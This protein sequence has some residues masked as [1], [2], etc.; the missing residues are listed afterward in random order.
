[1][2]WKIAAKLPGKNGQSLGFA[3]PVTGITGNKL[4][5]AGGAN[6]PDSMPWLGGKKKYY[7]EVFV[8]EKKGDGKLSLLET[9]SLYL[10]QKLAYSG[11]ITIPD[12]I[13]CIGGETD[14]G[15]TSEVFLLQY[16]DAKK[17]IIT[18]ELPSLPAA[19]ANMAVANIGQT[20]YAAGGE[21]G[22]KA[23]KTFFKMD[24]SASSPQW[25]ELP[26]LP[27]AVSHAVA[28]AQS[29][30]KNECV[31]VIGGRTKS[32]SGL[33]ELH[34]TVFCYDP[35]TNTWKKVKDISD[36]KT[37]TSMS[38]ATAV[39][40]GEELIL[41]IGG[42]KG[43]IFH[44]IETININ[45][46]NRKTAEEKERLQ[47][48]KIQLLNNHPG[49]SRDVL[50]YNTTK[51]CWEKI[52]ELPGFGPVTTTAVKWNDEIFIPSGEIKPGVR[53]PEVLMGKVKKRNFH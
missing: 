20:I 3:G 18:K 4:I 19:L 16:D 45:I 29:N 44:Q 42:D 9:K 41:L 33:S 2:Q 24:L 8:F 10:K 22:Q 25:K 7:D 12:G 15:H 34:S 47:A 43:T 49:F 26:P 39:A 48:E 13:V 28:V 17:N 32:A 50:A 36:G 53:T 40:F 35:K 52:G 46:A 31:Y 38:A 14:T 30:G 11:N 6:F 37:V 27:V 5:V 21:D 1:M 51:D 23:V